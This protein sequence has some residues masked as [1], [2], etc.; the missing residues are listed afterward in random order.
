MSAD[1]DLTLDQ[2]DSD[3]TTLNDSKDAKLP[4]ASY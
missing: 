1:F 4:I 3:D 2:V